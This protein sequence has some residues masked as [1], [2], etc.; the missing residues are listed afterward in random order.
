[1]DDCKSL[2]ESILNRDNP[3]TVLTVANDEMNEANDSQNKENCSSTP[4]HKNEYSVSDCGTTTE[5]NMEEDTCLN[6]SPQIETFKPKIGCCSMRFNYN[7]FKGCK[8]Y[9]PV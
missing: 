1:M 6:S 9:L 7:I 8:W 5:V 3:E 4:E 2:D